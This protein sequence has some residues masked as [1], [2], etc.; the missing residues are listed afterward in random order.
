M[1]LE[2]LSFHL[3]VGVMLEEEIHKETIDWAL[4]DSQED[5]RMSYPGWVDIVCWARSFAV[6]VADRLEDVGVESLGSSLD[7]V[8]DIVVP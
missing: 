5:L 4:V 6:V 7:W 1:S 3:Y 8:E 2:D